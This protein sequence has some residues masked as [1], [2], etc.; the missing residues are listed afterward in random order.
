MWSD[1]EV[2]CQMMDAYCE[3]IDRV[4]EITSATFN[5]MR[6]GY[7]SSTPG[8]VVVVFFM[9]PFWSMWDPKACG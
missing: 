8:G 5:A 1:Y 4:S 6:G 9:M 7:R 2:G 3:T